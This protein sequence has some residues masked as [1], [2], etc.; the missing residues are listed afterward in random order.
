MFYLVRKKPQKNSH[1]K[2]NTTTKTF[3]LDKMSLIETQA[4]QKKSH[5]DEDG[6]ME[7]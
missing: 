5:V 7:K 4:R 6:D 3:H 1:Q 2:K